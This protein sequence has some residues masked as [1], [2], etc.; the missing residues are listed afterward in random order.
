[1]AQA[2][3]QDTQLRLVFENGI[4]KNG[5]MKYK[6]KN[7]NNIATTASTDALYEAARAIVGLQGFTLDHVSRNDNHLITE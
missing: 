4:D 7:Y 2:I 3:I 1:M 5:K 6:T